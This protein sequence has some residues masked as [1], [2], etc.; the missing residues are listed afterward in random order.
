MRV[1]LKITDIIDVEVLQR[2]QDSFSD[3]TGLA[4]VTVDYKGN[5][6]TEY[7]N[8]SE[9][10]TCVRKES[11]NRDCCFQ[12]DAHGGIESARS[13]KPSI[14]ICHGGLVDLA[15]P[16]MVK[17]NYLGAIMAGQVKIDEEEMKRLPFGTSHELTDFS[18]NPEIMD[19]YDKTLKTTLTQV[20]SAAD[21][22]YTIANYLVEKQMIHIIQEEL[23]NKNLELMEEVK[24][25]SEVEASLKE[26]D[27]KAL[28]AQINPHFL[29]NVLNTIG[30]LAL[31][32]G[33]DK[34]QEMIY[35]F[36]D[37]MRYTLK[38]E[39]NNVVTLKEEMEHVQNY[40]SIQK[41]RL[42]NRLNYLVEVDEMAEDILCPFMT[43]KPFVEN[44]IIHAIEPNAR[45]GEVR[46]TADILKEIAILKIVD[47]GK[48]IPDDRI[49]KILDGTYEA[50]G[51]EKN[52][53]IGINNANKRLMY[54]YGV[55]YGVEI[56][57]ELE[58]GTEITIK[59][60]RKS[61]AGRGL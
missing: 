19:L 52:T 10:C 13:G 36:S 42:G 49:H 3:A 53:G 24:L 22:L 59:I 27:L 15:V 8:F 5:P 18:K 38:K 55:D 11:S 61:L 34:T 31:L 40:L 16:I 44:A 35:A 48:G 1:L 23:H 32:E 26:A 21:L 50:D 29:F 58:K 6:I 17:G 46:I 25:R 47:D 51:R 33:A 56:K 60:P 2:I 54:Y 30:R 45:G 41:M 14:Y 4:A 28:Q 9:Y 43:I 57:S 7:S 20:R 12:S 39:K 37:M